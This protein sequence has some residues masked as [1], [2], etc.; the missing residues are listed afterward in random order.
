LKGFGKTDEQIFTKLAI[1]TPIRCQLD[2][3]ATPTAIK[4]QRDANKMPFPHP[5]NA[6]ANYLTTDRRIC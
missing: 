1:Y 6:T 2:A 3:N 5:T 4:C